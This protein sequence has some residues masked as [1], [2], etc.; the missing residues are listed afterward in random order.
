MISRAKFFPRNDICR[1]RGWQHMSAVT[2]LFAFAVSRINFYSLAKRDVSLEI[3]IV[4]IITLEKFRW[5]FF[6]GGIRP[7]A[8]RTLEKRAE[9][10]VTRD[11]W[12]SCF[13]N[14]FL[15]SH[16]AHG[17]VFPIT[18]YLWSKLRMRTVGIGY[19]ADR[20]SDLNK[21]C[22]Q[23]LTPEGRGGKIWEFTFF[24]NFLAKSSPWVWKSA[25]WD[26]P[27]DFDLVS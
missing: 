27:A 24:E 5:E 26:S 1:I 16:L 20:S 3:T 15:L 4:F 7:L 6:G 21:L 22:T 25:V 13:L 18:L 9:L 12:L 2:T 17:L 8:R 19:C 10:S 23:M 11:C 14:L